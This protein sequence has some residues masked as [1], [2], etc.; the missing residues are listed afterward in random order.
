MTGKQSVVGDYRIY[1][2][3]QASTISTQK[4]RKNNQKTK[5]VICVTSQKKYSTSGFYL[6]ERM[7]G[8]RLC[9]QTKDSDM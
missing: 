9:V 5:R 1:K 8:D 4:T 6:I 2:Q 3:V 7:G